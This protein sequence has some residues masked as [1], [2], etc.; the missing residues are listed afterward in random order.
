MSWLRRLLNALRAG[1][2]EREIDRELSFHLTERA[3][4]L[5]T[6]GL[7][8][9]EAMRRAHRQFGNATVQAERTRDVDVAGW[10]DGLCRNVRYAVRSLVRTPAFTSTVVLTLALGIGANSA[11][12]SA[13]DAVLLRPLPFPDGDRLMQL[14]QT[15]E[16]KEETHIAPIRLEDWNRLNSTFEAITGYYMEDVSETSGDLPQIVRRAWVAPRFLEVWGV[17]PSRG[18]GFT[19]AEHEAGGPKAVLISDRY[20]RVRLGADPHVLDRSVRIGTDACPIVGVMPASFLFPDRDVDLWFPGQMG[21][22]LAQVR[23]ATWYLGVGRLE[24][25][26]TLKQARGNLAAVQAALG[27]RFPD[28]DAKVGVEIVPLKETMVSGVRSSLW[29][30]FGAVSVLLLI[31]CTNIAALLLSRAAHR[32]Q[33]IAIRLSLGASR[34]AVA[35]QLLT[36]AGVLALAGGAAGLF[37]A[38][39]A[40][41]AF[42]STTAGHARIDE[43]ALDGRVLLYSFVITVTVALLCGLLPAI[44]TARRGVAGTL[45]EAGRTH[46]STR[47]SVQWLLVGAQVTLSVMLLA[48]AGLFLRSMEELTRVD[49]GFE[50]SRVLT[51]RVS[52]TW[53]ETGAYDRLV[54][55]VDG[56]IEE[57][58]ALPGVDAAA[59]TGWSPPGVPT[60]WEVTF[61]LVE[62]RGDSTQRMVAEA[63]SVSPEY[64]ATMQIPVL[65]GELCRRWRFNANGSAPGSRD[66]MVNRAFAARYL[67]GWPSPLG[68]HLAELN[69]ESPPTRIVGV[70]GDARERGLAHEPGPTVYWC[71]SA[72]NPT[73]YFLVR[74]RAEPSAVAQTVRLKMKELEPLRSVY[75]ISPLEERIDEAFAENRLRTMLLVFFAVTALSLTCVGLYG[76]LSYLVRLRRREVGLR[77]ALGARRRDIIQ[78]FLKQGLRVVGLACVCGLALSFAFTRL[79]AGMLYGVSP[80]DPVTLST[81][82]GLVLA[83]AVL[84]ALVPAVRAALV[85]PM[86]VLREE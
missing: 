25:G 22:K 38:A 40:S 46:V 44:R 71:A 69:S 32:Q 50:P 43:I 9:E 31:A 34:T 77:L 47:S 16:G 30:L 24:P 10:M 19:A 78:Q 23:Y 12:F 21:T 26:V 37:V 28:T 20:W 84:A 51:F 4:Q 67:S 80:S 13:L 6:E 86:Q 42:R 49:P 36:E 82:V 5:R 73:P 18:R 55:R 48:C 1:R 64:F 8:A 74:T 61:G 75:D 85:E 7:S 41:T 83:V 76:T 56:T 54:Q 65:E 63:R 35:A 17:A 81:V 58:R 45:G 11:V 15:H 70:V 72:P 2:I 66:V 59:T 14:R 60:Q 53:A 27:K 3:D 79:L 29:L 33:E 39:A 62:A 52:A 57:L 68:L